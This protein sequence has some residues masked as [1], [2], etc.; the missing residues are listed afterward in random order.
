MVRN[1]HF[2]IERNRFVFASINGAERFLGTACQD[3]HDEKRNG[4]GAAEG[5]KHRASV[6][7][8]TALSNPFSTRIAAEEQIGLNPRRGFGCSHEARCTA[9]GRGSNFSGIAGPAP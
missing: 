4:A 8:T 3:E 1:F 9:I 2:W 5:Q 7:E 6:K